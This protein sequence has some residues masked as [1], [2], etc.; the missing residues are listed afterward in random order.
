MEAGNG[1]VLEMRFNSGEE[2]EELVDEFTVVI[3]LLAMLKKEFDRS[4]GLQMLVMSVVLP[5][6]R[7]RRF[8]LGLIIGYAL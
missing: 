3:T 7:E 6:L 2:L 1:G 5:V 8:D 4:R